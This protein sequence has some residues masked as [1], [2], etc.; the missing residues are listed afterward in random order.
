MLNL[1]KIFKKKA[2]VLPLYSADSFSRTDKF[3]GMK[4]VI[5]NP[6]GKFLRKGDK[7]IVHPT[8]DSEARKPFEAYIIFEYVKWTHRPSIEVCTNV[9]GKHS[10]VMN[11]YLFN[12]LEPISK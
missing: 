6:N 12:R 3:V 11:D 10:A 8:Q 5:N 7:V 9:P 4:Y 1:F 2:K